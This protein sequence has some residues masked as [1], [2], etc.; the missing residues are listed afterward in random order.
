MH[1][2]IKFVQPIDCFG[3]L[4]ISINAK[5]IHNRVCR[6]ALL[7]SCEGCKIDSPSVISSDAVKVVKSASK[8]SDDLCEMLVCIGL[9]CENIRGTNIL[10]PSPQ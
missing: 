8:M 6:R 10:E 7:I 2:W 4:Q 5:R 9:L 3:H 1:C